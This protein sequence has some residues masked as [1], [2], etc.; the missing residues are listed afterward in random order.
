[1]HAFLG[2][3]EGHDA[4]VRLLTWT[5]G[6]FHVFSNERTPEK[7]ITRRMESL[8]MESAALMDYTI[9]LDQAKID[10]DTVLEKVPM[11]YN[12]YLERMKDAPPVDEKLV[13]LIAGQLD[14]PSSIGEIAA[15]LN[16][17]SPKWKPVIYGFVKTGVIRVSQVQT[18]AR[19]AHQ[20][21]I[22]EKAQKIAREGFI[23]DQTGLY[24]E[25][26]YNFF[27]QLELARSREQHLNFSLIILVLPEQ[28]KMPCEA[29]AL[30]TLIDNIQ[31]SLRP[32]DLMCYLAPSAIG[33]LLPEK[34]K[35]ECQAMVQGLVQ[36][37]MKSVIA[38]PTLA[39]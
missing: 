35:E 3:S 15:R 30:Q 10:K 26:A 9:F 39:E 16:L 32:F 11:S 13:E 6:D 37:C 24:S 29:A 27:L 14:R 5:S 8:L 34:S 7:S 28:A 22:G 18:T 25:A 36:R 1:M 2:E 20:Q 23:N 21:M 17:S 31:I 33:L 19:I 38:T 4:I 12:E